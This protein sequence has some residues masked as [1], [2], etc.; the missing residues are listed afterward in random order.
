[1]TDTTR[2]SIVTEIPLKL[3]YTDSSTAQRV[4]GV[5]ERRVRTMAKEFD[6]DLLGL[7]VVSARKDGRY[8]CLDGAHRTEAARRV[9]YDEPILCRVFYDLT[10]ADENYLFD[11]Y[12]RADKVSSLSKFKARAIW[13]DPVAVDITKAAEETGWKIK[14]GSSAGHISCV[15]A[16]E[17][18]YTSGSGVL[19][20]GVYPPVLYCTLATISEA[21][22]HDYKVGNL[23][24]VR[25]IGQLIGR[26]GLTMWHESF[27]PDR[28]L[29]DMDRLIKTLSKQPLP[30]LMRDSRTLADLQ[31]GTIQA[32]FAK[33]AAAIYNRGIRKESN[34]LPEWNWVR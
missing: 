25:G 34:K 1:M 9:G 32:A 11:F 4:E 27:L 12:N 10:E 21:W 29:I 18:V 24:V 6:P 16:M 23:M 19:K 7:V 17:A 28:H 13:G 14:P 33:N 3:I 30:G 26:F 15:D 5:S 20:K 31:K 2:K 8:A 22:G